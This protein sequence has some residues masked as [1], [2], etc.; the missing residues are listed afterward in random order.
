MNQEFKLKI[1]SVF[2]ALFLAMFISFL[3]AGEASQEEISPFLMQKVKTV[4]HEYFNADL[5]DNFQVKILTGGYSAASIRIDFSDKSYV[6]R[7]I[8]ESEIPS[9]VN[10]ELYA[11]KKAAEIGVGPQIHWNSTDGYSI[12]MDC[13]PGETLTIDFSKKSDVIANIASLMRKVH[14]LPKN[15]L[16]SPTFKEH[17]DKIYF[18]CSVDSNCIEIWEA[19]NLII[20][21]GSTQLE[22]LESPS[23]NIHGDLNPRNILITSQ[24]LYFI[25]WSEEMYTEPFHDLAYFSVLMDY[26]LCEDALLLNSYLLRQATA[27]EK[28]RFFIAKKM[29]FARLA[30]GG[31]YVGNRL[32]KENKDET[33][34]HQLKD[35]SY[36]VGSFASNKDSLS[37]QFFLDMA[38]VAMHSANAIDINTIN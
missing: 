20:C 3:D 16:S 14:S 4:I 5:D 23:V 12:L 10:A 1:K 28:K 17:M 26:N 29:N 30:L 21:E 27:K 31:L 32:S 19:A 35:W 8:K 18:G 6:L 37:G 25:D 38:K 36:Y 24:R 22:K 15:P 7:I 34:P 9:S 13:I 11:M 33:T 2:F